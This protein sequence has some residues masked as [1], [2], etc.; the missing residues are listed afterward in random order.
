MKVNIETSLNQEI[1][2]NQFKYGD[3]II[4]T[5]VLDKEYINETRTKRKLDGQKVH[6]IKRYGNLELWVSPV[7]I[8]ENDYLHASSCL[9][10]KTKYIDKNYGIIR[11]PTKK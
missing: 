1:N 9:L 5:Y 6:V 8:P 3:I 7:I 4:L 11:E 2:S 10:Y